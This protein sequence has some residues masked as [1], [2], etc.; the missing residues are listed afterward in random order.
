MANWDELNREFDGLL[1]KISDKDWDNWAENRERNKAMRRQ[2]LEMKA[3]IQ[4]IKLFLD[5]RIND[6]IIF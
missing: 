4:S 6:I 1:E 5:K 3:K 2:L